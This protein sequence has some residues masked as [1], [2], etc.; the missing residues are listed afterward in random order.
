MT[1]INKIIFYFTLNFL[2]FAIPVLVQSVSS[3]S[4]TIADIADGQI[5]NMWPVCANRK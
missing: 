3:T 5:F 1:S 4:S 2:V